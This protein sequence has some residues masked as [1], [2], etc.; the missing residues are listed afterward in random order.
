MISIIIPTLDEACALP[1]TL[2]CAMAQRGA[3]EII[4]V[5]GG[6][7]DA[8][9]RIARQWR[10]VRIAQ[11]R[12]GRGVQLNQGARLA[13]GDTLLFLHADTLLSEGALAM[14]EAS[15]AAWGGFH[16]RFSGADWRLRIVER[17]HNWRCAKTDIFYGDQAMW[18]RRALFETVGGFVE[19]PM[20]DIALSERLRGRCPPAFLDA[21]VI[22]DSRKFER[23]GVWLS[24][25]RV[26]W[27]LIRRRLGWRVQSPFFADIR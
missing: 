21:Q 5:D 7:R 18:V 8:T 15:H 6:S 25:A 10:G 11:T 26:I 16:H 12:R 17:L 13:N 24:L 27:I 1:A 23:C 19:E 4:V 2:A 20:E 9:L 22:T 3:K 14:I